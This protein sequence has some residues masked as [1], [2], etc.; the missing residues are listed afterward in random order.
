M[1]KK[2]HNGKSGP[3]THV[4]NAWTLDDRNFEFCSP[5]L[6]TAGSLDTELLDAW[7]LDIWTLDAWS[8]GLWT[9]R[10]LDS[11]CLD[12]SPWTKEILSIFSDIYFFVIIII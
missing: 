8:F 1:S 6:R 3:W 11:G 12:C 9:T 4:L 5:E 2:W 7:T 10:R